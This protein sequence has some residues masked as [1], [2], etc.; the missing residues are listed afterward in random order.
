MIG[1]E[2]V[3]LNA[4]QVDD[5][6]EMIDKEEILEVEDKIEKALQK[7]AE[8]KATKKLAR[9]KEA[10]ESVAKE[11]DSGTPKET[12]AKIDAPANNLP[13]PPPISI[14]QTKKGSDSKML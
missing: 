10:A 12:K 2:N 14:D 8:K 1:K 6:I 11:L 7:E 3:N 4:K 9:E 5:I 13:S